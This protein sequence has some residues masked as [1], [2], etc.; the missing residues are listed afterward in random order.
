M[1]CL[2]FTFCF[3]MPVNTHKQ[4]QEGSNQ[5]S[6]Q[7]GNSMIKLENAGLR[8]PRKM[9][10]GSGLHSQKRIR[11][12]VS[13]MVG[14]RAPK[15]KFQGSRA[16]GTPPLGPWVVKS[17]LLFQTSRSW[18]SRLVIQ[19]ASLIA[20]AS[21]GFKVVWLTCVICLTFDSA[22]C[23]ITYLTCIKSVTSQGKIYQNKVGELKAHVKDVLRRKIDCSNTFLCPENSSLRMA[24]RISLWELPIEM[25]TFNTPTLKPLMTWASFGMAR[26][27]SMNLFLNLAANL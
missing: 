21:T 5:E 27:K 6:M 24:E 15:Q 25:V 3:F 7:S 17:Q 10:L 11:A 22:L 16:P 2:L 23:I 13:K 8:A 4:T 26:S 12:P 9:S 20:N 1:Y 19:L 14:L 18:N